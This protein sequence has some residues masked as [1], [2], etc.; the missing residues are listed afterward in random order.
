[1]IEID[2]SRVAKT[3]LFD[4][5]GFKH[6]VLF[7]KTN[8]TWISHPAA[9]SAWRQARDRVT[10]LAADES[11]KNRILGCNT[12]RIVKEDI[13]DALAPPVFHLEETK[14]LQRSESGAPNLYSRIGTR[15]CQPGL[16]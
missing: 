7:S 9:E 2:L 8:R 6:Q 12:A 1:M 3:T 10:A 14:P 16:G 4:T 13:Q 15:A 11:N 5:D